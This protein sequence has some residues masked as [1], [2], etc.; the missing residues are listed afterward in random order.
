MIDLAD[1]LLVRRNDIHMFFDLRGIHH[2]LALVVVSGLTPTS[3]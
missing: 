2:A 3:L 1:H